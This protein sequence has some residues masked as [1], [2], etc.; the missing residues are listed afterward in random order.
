MQ[1]I[2]LAVCHSLRSGRKRKPGNAKMPNRFSPKFVVIV[3][4]KDME[5]VSCN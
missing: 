2:F 4:S 1:N 3:V 5:S